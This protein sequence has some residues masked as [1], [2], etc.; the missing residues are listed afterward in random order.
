MKTIN[1]LNIKDTAIETMTQSQV[2]WADETIKAIINQTLVDEQGRPYMAQDYQSWKDYLF[3]D[4]RISAE[5]WQQDL[6]QI[7]HEGQQFL[8]RAGEEGRLPLN[9]DA[10]EEAFCDDTEC[11][12]Y[13]TLLF[14][15]GI[16]TPDGDILP[17]GEAMEAGVQK[18]E[19][20]LIIARSDDEII[21]A[22]L[23]AASMIF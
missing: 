3:G 8:L 5:S 1:S 15:L 18:I 9:L 14:T 21:R 6:L 2:E 11:C 16:I 17:A 20:Y 12:L 13:P 23:V 22:F 4:N 7:I 10:L 19:G